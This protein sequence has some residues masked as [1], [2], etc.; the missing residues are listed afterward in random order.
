MD[1][2]ETFNTL[3]SSVSH[4]NK[5]GHNEHNLIQRKYLEGI[6]NQP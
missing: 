4:S 6:N 5:T 2:E 1:T 3:N